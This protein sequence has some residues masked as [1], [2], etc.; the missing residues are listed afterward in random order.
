M[1]P[2]ETLETILS[3]AHHARASD[4]HLEPLRAA[5]RVR[6]RIDGLLHEWARLPIT[7][8]SGLV[9]TI[10][11]WARL[12]LDEKRLPLDGRFSWQ[13]A[14]SERPQST[15][16][17]RVAVATGILGEGV[18]LRR[19][20]DHREVRSCEKLGI[21]GPILASITAALSGA[22]GMVLVSGPT[23][24]GKTTSLYAML[25]LL[26]ERALKI[27]TVEDP[28]E[29]VVEGVCQVAVNASIGFDAAG[30]LKAILR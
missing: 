9:S 18:T 20:D 15:Q 2:Q 29:R 22:D 7:V 8:A 27:I 23:G 14:K 28:V 6:F 25:E 11:L 10:K 26:R 16:Q 24:S 21:P 13:L 17:Y 4:I 30:A 19:I 3:E 1:T 12:P 5:L